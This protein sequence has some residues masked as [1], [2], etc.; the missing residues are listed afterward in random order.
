[1]EAINVAAAV[2]SM[3]VAVAVPVLFILYVFRFRHLKVHA[4]DILMGIIVCYFAQTVVFT[5]LM[6]AFAAVPGLQTLLV[7]PVGQQVLYC[8]VGA[9]CFL[10]GWYVVWALV[11]HRQFSEGQVS[12]L[13]VGAC[14]IK[15]A[16]D[17]LSA[18][19]SNLSVA[20]RIAN[21][22]LEDLLAGMVNNPSVDVNAL[23]EMYRSYSIPQYL[24]VGILAIL[25][26]QTTYLLLLQIA[27]RQ[28]VWMQVVFV[29]VFSLLY[30]F[31]LEVPVPVYVVLGAMVF[32]GVQ[33]Y[34]IQ[35][36]MHAY[37]GGIQP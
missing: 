4:P 29:V 12:R 17:I 6:N 25:L 9:A 23:V 30:N 35:Q 24:Y 32:M 8:A 10:G 33:L 22:S 36:I 34:F 2:F 14:C 37:L 31:T 28:P 7:N 13:T 15:I 19:W 1:M 11:Y 20:L 21:G 3:V 16:A 27:E 5:L 26:V 18:A